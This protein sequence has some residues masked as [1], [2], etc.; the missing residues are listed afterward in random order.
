[1]S[2]FCFNYSRSLVS[3]ILSAPL[4]NH[5]LPDLLIRL[6]L[7]RPLIAPLHPLLVCFFI[8]GLVALKQTADFLIDLLLLGLTPAGRS[9]VCLLVLSAI[10]RWLAISCIVACCL[11]ARHGRSRCC[12]ACTSWQTT[13]GWQKRWYLIYFR[14]ALTRATSCGPWCSTDS[15]TLP[16]STYRSKDNYQLQVKV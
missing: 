14:N 7:Y 9:A 16:S 4:V 11:S 12:Q 2:H 1:M 6:I 8:N 3:E 15:H 5:V 13:D 10:T